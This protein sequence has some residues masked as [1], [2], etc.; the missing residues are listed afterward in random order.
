MSFRSIRMLAANLWLMPAVLTSPA[1]AMTLT[2]S[3]LAPPASE[4]ILGFDAADEGSY[5][6]THGS[7]VAVDVGQTF[8]AVSPMTLDKITLKVRAASDDTRGELVTL[9]LGTF[10]DETDAEMN[11][12]LAAE[13]ALLPQALLPGVTLYLTFDLEDVVLEAG[14]H[15]G[16]L[17]GFTGGGNVNDAR[18]EVLHLGEDAYAGGQAVTLEAAVQASAMEHDLAFFLHGS[19]GVAGTTL[20]LHSGRFE[21]E[22]AWENRF[23]GRGMA[24]PV[25]MTDAGGYFYFSHPDN[26]EL[27]IKVLDACVDPYR[28]FWVFAAGLTDVE[29]TITVRD[30]AAMVERTYFNPMYQPFLPIQDTLAFAT[31]DL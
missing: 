13:T 11:E 3:P 20:L 28:H 30:T 10:T 31:C 25:A 17:L 15:Y 29:V 27:V 8:L 23:G 14:R 18:L 19:A 22:V 9:K 16:F 26:V 7:A 2:T 12:V 21:V 4:V 1:A 24:V 5:L 6:C